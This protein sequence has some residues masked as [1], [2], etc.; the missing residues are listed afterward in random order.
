M[1]D[2]IGTIHN[3]VGVPSEGELQDVNSNTTAEKI[4]ER[5]C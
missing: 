3:T 5:F 2:G 1:D 4:L